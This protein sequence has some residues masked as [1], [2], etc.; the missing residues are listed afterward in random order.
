[1]AK[2]LTP[3][4]F[5]ATEEEQALVK[6]VAEYGEQNISEFVR[7]IVLIYCRE[8]VTEVGMGQIEARVQELARHRDEQ[9]ARMARIAGTRVSAAGVHRGTRDSSRSVPNPQDA[10]SDV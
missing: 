6:L 10:L 9:R 5:R 4:T 7:D 1:M 2:S 8:L 3:M